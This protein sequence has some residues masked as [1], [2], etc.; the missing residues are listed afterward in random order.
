VTSPLALTVMLF[1]GTVAG[2][3]AAATRG[4][5]LLTAP[6]GHRATAHRQTTRRP[7][8]AMIVRSCSAMSMF[9]LSGTWALI[10]R[11]V[12]PLAVNRTWWLKVARLHT[13]RRRGGHKGN[14]F[15]L[16]ETRCALARGTARVPS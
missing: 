11:A 15:A 2:A 5:G 8:L 7:P 16:G 4:T 6:P 14:S 3:P 9:V 10:L 12:S 13:V 1:G